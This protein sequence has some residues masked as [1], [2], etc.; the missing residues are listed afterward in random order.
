[1][2]NWQDDW[3]LGERTW[4]TTSWLCQSA[5]FLPPLTYNTQSMQ[6]NTAFATLFPGYILNMLPSKA[7]Q[8]PSSSLSRKCIRCMGPYLPVVNLILIYLRDKKTFIQVWYLILVNH[9]QHLLQVLSL[10]TSGPVAGATAASLAIQ[11]S[12]GTS[13]YLL[14]QCFLMVSNRIPGILWQVFHHVSENMKSYAPKDYF[15]V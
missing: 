15:P 5:L 3:A 8:N 1:M 14:V 6:R 2:Q 9:F 4:S 11:S 12:R 13:L 7:V 10:Q